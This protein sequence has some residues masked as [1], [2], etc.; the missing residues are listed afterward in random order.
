MKKF[1]LY[2]SILVLSS[3]QLPSGSS[4]LIASSLLS[5]TSSEET[6]VSE[7]LSSDL[8][9]EL[10]P[11]SSEEV[12]SSSL[13]PS[14]SEESSLPSSEATFSYTYVASPGP[15]E[16]FAY[17][18]H[19]PTGKLLSRETPFTTTVTSIDDVEAIYRRV[20]EYF[21]STQFEGT[22]S[23]YPR[24]S[25]TLD[26]ES[27][28]FEDAVNGSLSGD[29]VVSGRAARLHGGG[30]IVTAFDLG[31]ISDITLQTA[32]YGSDTPNA[33]LRLYW[34]QD[35]L[36]WSPLAGYVPTSQ[37]TFFHVEVDLLSLYL[38]NAYDPSLPMYLKLYNLNYET[39]LD[40]V[41]I[42]IDNLVIN[43]IQVPFIFPV[44][45]EDN[46]QLSFHYNQAIPSVL[47]VGNGW[48]PPT[49]EVT[50][51]ETLAALPCKMD[52]N[53]NASQVGTY[54]LSY[55]AVD[56]FG[57]TI[58]DRYTL[59]VLEDLDIL[60]INYTGFYDGIEGLYG[61]A[62]Q[63]AL[64][65]KSWAAKQAK[66]YSEGKTLLP[67]SDANPNIPGQ[68][69]AIYTG[70]SLSSI[71]DGGTTWQREHVW[72]N[73]RLGVRRV[74][75]TDANIASDLHNLR[76]IESSIN[77]SRSNKWFDAT[78]TSTTYFPGEDAGDVARIVFYMLMMYDHLE[79][80]NTPVE[81]QEY[82]VQG[83]KLGLVDYLI[84]AHTLDPVSP[85]EM[86]RNAVLTQ[87]QGNP[88]PFIDYPYLLD[89]M[90]L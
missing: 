45:D 43:T 2:L 55:T 58:V 85:F 50:D 64:R 36:Y 60:D 39:P 7:S 75:E 9:S 35:G 42:N 38:V 79:L 54:E 88:N 46:D 73:S 66:P 28:W 74:G 63:K 11:S 20:G 71:W 32:V 48:T 8:S 23:S 62:L 51:E 56:L 78:T 72:P 67:I 3:C 70:N 41:R 37:L 61:H 30:S 5:S 47:E 53:L 89:L 33:E 90:M 17:W 52:T 44:K 34:S 87:N 21:Y 59:T 13:I 26:G 57:Y 84:E 65:E 4:S 22:K 6:S 14:S 1:T 80:S 18:R 24:A 68:A 81:Q 15:D 77:A 19:V 76:F 69:V 83:A 49:C 27:W 82:M 29:K 25:V 40:G 12:S 31:L 16:L 86:T 10:P